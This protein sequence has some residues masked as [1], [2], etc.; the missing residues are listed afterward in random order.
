MVKFKCHQCH[1]IHDGFPELGFSSP[2]YWTDPSDSESNS[3][4]FLQ[5]ELCRIDEDFFIRGCLE[6][7]IIA[8]DEF[9]AYGVWISVSE[10]NFD[11]YRQHLKDNTLHLDD[12]YTGYICNSIPG[13]ENT[14]D[15]RAAAYLREDL[16]PRI[17]L[18]PTEHPL[19]VLQ[20][21]GMTVDQLSRIVADY[22]H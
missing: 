11:R 7:P 9:Y 6:I 2:D 16:R 15:L 21:E 19:A 8:E 10:K 4:C 20:H 1:E 3:D 5:S 13:Y 18:E 14:L 22:L 17:E 12:R